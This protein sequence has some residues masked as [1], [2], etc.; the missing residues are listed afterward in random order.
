MKYGE[1]VTVIIPIY[2]CE[3][4]L[5]RCLRSIEK[6][7]Y[8]N[9]EIILVDDGSTDSSSKIYSE[10]KRECARNIRI[11]LQSNQGVSAARNNGLKNAHGSYVTFVDG[12]DYVDSDYVEF[13]INEI[14]NYNV[15]LAICGY[16]F[17]TEQNKVLKESK[18]SRVIY[19]NSD[20]VVR[21]SFR[22]DMFQGFVC[23]KMFSMKIIKTNN[24]FFYENVNAY[25]DHLFFVQ[26]LNFVSKAVYEN[27]KL[28]SYMKHKG[29]SIHR[30]V[31]LSDITAYEVM[32][33]DSPKKIIDSAITEVRVRAYPF[34]DLDEKKDEKRK[35]RKS[36]IKFLF[37]KEK[38]LKIKLIM[39][40][41][42]ILPISFFNY[43]RSRS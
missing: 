7:T 12:D 15:E 1:L 11:I 35:L 6:Q 8:D 21:D 2:N 30:R 24:L 33:R 31:S 34:L 38:R 13:L 19:K 5:D 10:F 4:F 14:V 32:Y 28:Y 3:R 39:I 43:F 9:I 25:E 29:S 27:R 42:L 23:A 26:Y 16:V 20:D 36:G 40:I 37:S 41:E 18:K 22:T 17:K